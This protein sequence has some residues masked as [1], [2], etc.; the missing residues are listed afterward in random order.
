[1][2]LFLGESSSNQLP[3]FQDTFSRHPDRQPNISRKRRRATPLPAPSAPKQRKPIDKVYIKD[4]IL[5]P[6]PRM[7]TVPRGA[8]REALYDDGFVI[9]GFKLHS[10]ATEYELVSTI[11][12]AFSDRFSF[13]QNSVKFLFVRAVDKKIV[14]LRNTEEI[15]GE[16][17]KHL[18]GPRDRPIYIRATEDLSYLLKNPDNFT[19][20]EE[21]FSSLS[22]DVDWNYLDSLNHPL[23][24]SP[25]TTVSDSVSMPEEQSSLMPSNNNRSQTPSMGIN[26]NSRKP[27]ESLS[28]PSSSYT[29]ITEECP[30][31]KLKFGKAEIQGH[32]NFCIDQ[33]KSKPLE[34]T[35]NSLNSELQDKRK[36][37]MSEDPL[38]FV[39]RRNNLVKD[40]LKKMKIFFEKS[41]IKPITVEFVGEEAVDDGGPLLDL[42]T[43]FYDRV[44]QHLFS[45]QEM[46][47]TFRHDVHSLEDNI[48]K[49]YGKFVAIGFL[50]GCSGPH[51]FSSPVAKYIIS[52]SVTTCQ[53]EDIPCYDVKTK[54]ES[55]SQATSQQE[56]DTVLS[57]FDERFE[58][59]YNKMNITLEDKDDLVNKVS[60]HWVIT[61]QNE[62]IQQFISGLR[63]FAILDTLRRFENESLKEFVYDPSSVTSKLFQDIYTYQYSSENSDER[64]LEEDIVYSWCNFLDEAAGSL[65]P[66]ASFIDIYG[67]KYEEKKCVVTLP[68]VLYFLTGSRFP[69]IGGLAK[70]RIKFEHCGKNSGKRAT[71][72]TCFL[73]LEIPVSDRYTEK[74]NKSIVED[75]LE[76]PGFGRC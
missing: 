4:C 37:F 66:D 25:T 38:K 24:N 73:T 40:V 48:F 45:G 54:L 51:N 44:P 35:F 68:D 15:S 47:Y 33:T 74:F 12:S 2:F 14:T 1:M 46:H 60:R 22:E 20:G 18:C 13:I 36:K 7:C 27:V 21:N 62:E 23:N 56:L 64:K 31:C 61:R 26:H 72:S 49:L 6:S 58:A 63:S 39:V 69:P 9:S 67:E 30:V 57:D 65:L 70:G 50:Q 16:V 52:S 71:V 28:E 8:C 34:Q 59:G 55:V 3:S 19:F 75:I 17:L 41:E 11:E 29:H 10:T 43:S 53:V 42:F 76:S 32:V 5:L